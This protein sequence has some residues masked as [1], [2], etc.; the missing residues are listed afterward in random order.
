MRDATWHQLELEMEMVKLMIHKQFNEKYSCF[1]KESKQ[2]FTNMKRINLIHL[3][4]LILFGNVGE[5]FI[6]K[7]K[8]KKSSPALKNKNK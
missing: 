7:I 2:K 5:C 4:I 6:L 3:H 8:K 1:I